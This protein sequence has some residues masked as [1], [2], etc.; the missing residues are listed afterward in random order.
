VRGAFCHVCGQKDDDFRRPL[1]TLTNEFMGDV[2]QWDS[3]VLRSIVPFLAMPG[4]LT[5]AYMRGRRQQFVSPLRLYLVVSIVFFLVLGVSQRAI[6]MFT[7]PPP[8]NMA[9]AFGLE[10]QLADVDPEFLQYTPAPEIFGNQITISMFAVPEGQT[11]LPPIPLDE[12]EEFLERINMAGRLM[13]LL[14]GVN[15]A[16][17]DPRIF[18]QVLNNWVP[19]LMVI[20]VPFFALIM[21]A[22]YVRRKVWFIDH[23]VFSLHYHSFMFAVLLLMLGL[24]SWFDVELQG[25]GAAFLFLALMGGYLYI[26][27][28]RTYRGGIFKTF[29]KFMILASAYVNVFMVSLV[30]ITALG[31]ANLN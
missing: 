28:L 30:L 22:L 25:L 9:E 10:E 15:A 13:P 20:L 7:G 21:A 17:D 11:Q 6:F 12:A 18:N 8:V 24:A 2:F 31:L 23:L 3:R 4:S 1:L 16:V 14:I 5:R 26:A 19:R 27:M 29:I